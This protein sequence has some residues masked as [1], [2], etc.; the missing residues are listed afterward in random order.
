MTEV[1][2]P[3]FPVK[4]LVKAGPNA[5]AVLVRHIV[6]TQGPALM[7]DAGRHHEAEDFDVEEHVDRLIRSQLLLARAQGAGGGALI[8]AT[9]IPAV[10]TGPGTALAATVTTMLADLTALAWIQVR[11]SLMIAAAYGHDLSDTDT[12]VRE[13]LL[14]SGLD[15]AAGQGGGRVLGAGGA[16][17][18]RRLLERY[19]RGPALQSVK[20]MFRLVGIKFSRAALVRGLPLI[21]IPAGAVV[22]DV[23]TRRAGHKA[24]KYYRTLPTAPAN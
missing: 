12:R 16:R 21:N 18:G 15:L 22:S 20:A 9:Q 13:V 23:T 11:M 14:L 7:A 19:L 1:P 3:K 5:P 6:E 10:A 17:V 24:R 2:K 8:S 4:E